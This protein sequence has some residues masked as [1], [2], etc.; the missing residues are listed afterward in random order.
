MFHDNNEGKERWVEAGAPLKLMQEIAEQLYLSTPGL[1]KEMPIE[2]SKILGSKYH[3]KNGT[4]L[5]RGG[6]A[7]LPTS[8]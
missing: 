1:S 2:E 4:V 8:G 7:E 5:N 3:A 6:G